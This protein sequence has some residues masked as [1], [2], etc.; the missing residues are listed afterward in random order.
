M[1]YTHE[2]V[3]YG[4]LVLKTQNRLTANSVS[5]LSCHVKSILPGKGLSPLPNGCGSMTPGSKPKP[6][7]VRLL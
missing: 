4:N 3:L 5:S 2:G 6:A 7:A 1:T